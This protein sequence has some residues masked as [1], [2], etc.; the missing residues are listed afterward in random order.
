ML[1]VKSAKTLHK[2]LLAN[3]RFCLVMR[4]GITT[5]SSFISLFFPAYASYSS[6]G[7]YTFS[8]TNLIIAVSSKQNRLQRSLCSILIWS[9]ILQNFYSFYL[10]QMSYLF[11]QHYAIYK[12]NKFS[13]FFIIDYSNHKTTPF[14]HCICQESKQYSIND[15]S[16]NSGYISLIHNTF[17]CR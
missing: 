17:L 13:S 8:T 14:R 15:Q 4:I 10:F 5:S 1:G 11:L 2:L 6:L 9:F 3:L 12:S 7:T 16:V